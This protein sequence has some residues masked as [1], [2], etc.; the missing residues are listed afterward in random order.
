[1]FEAW[2]QQ[3]N[4]SE[5]IK[6]ACRKAYNAGEEDNFLHA[7]RELKDRDVII[8]FLKKRITKEKLL[9]PSYEKA[10]SRIETEIRCFIEKRRVS[11]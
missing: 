6:E 7:N 2:W 1:M 11:K 5:E 4:Y 8:N 3:H 10:V 9:S